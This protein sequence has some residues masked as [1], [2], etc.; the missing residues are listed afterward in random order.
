MWSR[1]SVWVLP[2]KLA[3]SLPFGGSGAQ[4]RVVGEA[5]E[6]SRESVGA[7]E[8]GAG[9]EVSLRL[10]WLELVRLDKMKFATIA[11]RGARW[12]D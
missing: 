5:G 12:R 3:T 8:I 6:L 10:R 11:V 1:E 4:G 9:V 2:K 7:V